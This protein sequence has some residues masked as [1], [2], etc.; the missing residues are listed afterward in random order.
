MQLE[1][2]VRSLFRVP[3][4]E[5]TRLDFGTTQLPWTHVH[6]GVSVLGVDF[7]QPSDRSYRGTVHWDLIG[8]QKSPS[9]S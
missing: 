6:H 2:L 5:V 9:D 4:K 7:P 8:L 3:V 1:I